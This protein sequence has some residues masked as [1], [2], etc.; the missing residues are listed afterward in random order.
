[1]MTALPFVFPN[2]DFVF[3]RRDCSA[4][5]RLDKLIYET[6][7]KKKPGP[8]TVRCVHLTKG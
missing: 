8:R 5:T 6:K 1:M 3:K 2:G 4:C 7:L